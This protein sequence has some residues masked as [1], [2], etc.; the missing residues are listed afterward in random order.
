MIITYYRIITYY[1]TLLHT[2][3]QSN[4]VW[5][6]KKRCYRRSDFWTGFMGEG[7]F[8]Q[9]PKG[10]AFPAGRTA[11]IKVLWHEMHP[12]IQQKERGVWLELR[13]HGAER[14]KCLCISGYGTRVCPGMTGSRWKL[15]SKDVAPSNWHLRKLYVQ[16]TNLETGSPG[17]G[18][19]K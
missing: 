16:R 1:C 13:T 5:E 6:D 14:R 17:Q 10:M 7:S 4:Y 8:S 15:L 18:L 9:M 3:R 12:K 19:E 11:C 2:G